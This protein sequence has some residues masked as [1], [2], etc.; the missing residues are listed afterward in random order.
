MLFSD[1]LRKL[2]YLEKICLVVGQ[3][4]YCSVRKPGEEL[5]EEF[6][7]FIY[8][9]MPHVKDINTGFSSV[10]ILTCSDKIQTLKSVLISRIF[11]F[12][13]V[14]LKIELYLQCEFQTLSYVR[15]PAKSQCVHER[16][17]LPV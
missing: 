15:E 13:A 5:Q 17:F 7:P 6:D 11:F 2:T 16:M 14:F 1:S 4:P 3:N 8:K 9:Q 12:N 10:Q